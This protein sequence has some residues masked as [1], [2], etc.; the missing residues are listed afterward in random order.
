M[1]RLANHAGRDYHDDLGMGRLAIVGVH[2]RLQARYLADAGIAAGRFS[3]CIRKQP[4][5]HGRFAFHRG[6]ISFKGSRRQLR[7]VIDGCGSQ[8]L[9]LHFEIQL[10]LSVRMVVRRDFKRE[11]KVYIGELRNASCTH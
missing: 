3:F 5:Q 1:K 2:H 7:D 10:H 8:A 11:P 9:D 4:C 6:D